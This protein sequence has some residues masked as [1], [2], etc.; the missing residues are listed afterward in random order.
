VVAGLEPGYVRL[1]HTDQPPE[2]A[3][4]QPML[5]TVPH[6]AEANLVGEAGPVVLGT[7]G[8]VGHVFFVQLLG[9]R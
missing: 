7:V 5:G 3:L 8:R 2:R 1:A 9:R 4:A 6:D